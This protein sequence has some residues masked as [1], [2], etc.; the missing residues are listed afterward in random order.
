MDPSPGTLQ[1][2]ASALLRVGRHGEAIDVYRRL[3]VAHPHQADAWYNLGYLYKA[4]GRFDEALAAYQ[5]AL[6]LGIAEPEEVHLNRAAILSDHLRQDA[7]AERELRAALALNPRYAPALLNLGN[8]H[9]ERGERDA[10]IQCYERLL[11]Q[12]ASSE[13]GHELASEALARLAHLRPA[14]D[15]NDPMLAELERAALAATNDVLRANLLFALGRALDRIERYDEA[16]DAFSRANRSIGASYDPAAVE[17]STNALIAAFSTPAAQAP[18]DVDF[19][20]P[21]FICGMF[22]S[23][24]TLL[25]QA[26]GRHRCVTPGG[27][28]DILPR[29]VSGPLAPF[30]STMETAEPERAARLANAY[31]THLLRLFPQAAASTYVTDKRPDNFRLIGLIKRL[32]PQAKIIHTIRHPL[33]NGLSIFMQHLNPAVASYA[34]D[35]RHIGHYYGQY[36]R[37][38]AHWKTLYPDSILEFDYDAFV[39]EPEPTLRQLLGRLGLTWDPGC[40][41]FH[42]LGNTVKTASYWQVRRPLYGEASGRWRRYARHLTPL[43]EALAHAAVELPPSD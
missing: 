24:S 17:R 2:Q 33:D 11:E 6:E 35:L 20:Q 14:S 16:F 5:R 38:M 42:R 32:F 23:G 28:L 27:E 3:L 40:L 30:P 26:L 21:L 39:R 43:R 36:R 29:F 1:R 10:A 9:E 34:S 15:R 25:E 18:A 19:A 31:R 4:Q 41:D 12:Q 7:A 13:R 22:R 37:L 8:L